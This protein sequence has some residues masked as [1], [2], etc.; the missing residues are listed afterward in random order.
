MKQFVQSQLMVWMNF[1][2]N[3]NDNKIEFDVQGISIDNLDTL[4]EK[5]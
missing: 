2:K 1:V 4:V 3:N 5:L